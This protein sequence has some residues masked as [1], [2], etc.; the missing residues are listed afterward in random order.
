MIIAHDFGTTGN[1]ATLVDDEGRMLQ[2]VTVAY[3]VE[4]GT[5]GKAEQNP[6]DWW[7]AVAEATR[8]LLE[9]SGR[10]G[11]DIDAV[12]FSGQMMGIV[13]LD[14]HGEVVRPAIIWADTRSQEQADRV[15][16][17]VSMEEAYRI[18]GHRLNATYSLTKLMWLR[19]TEPENFARMTSFVL[20]KDYVVYRLT[21]ELA[22]DPSDA[23]STN[24]YDQHAATWSDTLIEAAELERSL[25]P[26]IVQ[27]TNVVG[28]V[29]AEAA[30]ETGLA[31][32]TKVVMGGGDGPMAAL[33]AGIVTLADGAYAYLGSSSWVSVS[34]TE[35]LVD[36]QMRS[37]TFNHVVP[38]HF[39][40]TATMQAGGASLAWIVDVLSQEGTRDFDG[41]LAAAAEVEAA[42][43]DLF[44]LPHLIGERS[45]YWN[46]KA[47]GV[48]AGLH[49]DH[50]KAHMTRAVVEGVVF[51]LFTGLRAF[52]ENGLKVDH[53]DAIGGAAA[54]PLML[55]LMANI[56][57]VP[58][59]ARDISEEANAIG[60][61]VVAGVGAGIFD[62]MSIA[63][64]LSKRVI[65]N[66]PSPVSVEAYR[67]PYERFLDAYRRIEPW[68]EGA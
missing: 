52:T 61:A 44:F 5:D 15:L 60:A 55:D 2:S 28:T 19:D 23:S 31:E 35:P 62:D 53:I 41:L 36:P 7:R 34:A 37:M 54:S 21:G 1:K 16:E 45:P 12:S 4:W 63:K 49:I 18:T 33:G 64:T 22:T 46:P 48:F 17:R 3:G 25:F 39:V 11:A 38:D 56:W 24:A 59:A 13:P 67:K 47:R 29:S 65:E 50:G 51:N 43:Q 68:F 8:T 10:N 20:A 57:D 66:K 27:S 26:Q 32:G 6:H 30:R 14:N 40:P 58:V 9:K 42:T